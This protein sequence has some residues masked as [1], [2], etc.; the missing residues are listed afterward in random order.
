MTDTIQQAPARADR[1]LWRLRGQAFGAL[2]MLIIQFAIGM[3]VNLYGT[4]PNADKGSGFLTAIGRAF[5]NGP[6]VLA[7][8]AALGLLIL[9]A[10]AALLV[11]AILARLRAVIGLSAVGLLAVLA[12]AAGGASFV[13][14]GLASASLTMALATAAA[15]LCYA[16]CLMALSAGRRPGR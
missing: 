4:V 14:N 7:I 12:A 11:R 16:V 5:S 8:H 10:A 9:L 15:M 6:A 2:V 3:V 1:E 13:G